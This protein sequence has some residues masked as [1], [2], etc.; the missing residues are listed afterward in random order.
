MDASSKN[1]CTFSCR[2]DIFLSSS[3]GLLSCSDEEDFDLMS[4]PLDVNMEFIA[5]VLTVCDQTPLDEKIHQIVYVVCSSDA[6][7][8]IAGRSSFILF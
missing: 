3:L 7:M 4:E 1:Q 8:K 5:N 2:P 6:P